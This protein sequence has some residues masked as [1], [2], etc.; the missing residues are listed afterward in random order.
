MKLQGSD[1]SLAIKNFG[2]KARELKSRL[3]QRFSFRKCREV[4][5]S[6]KYIKNSEEII[7]SIKEPGCERMESRVVSSAQDSKFRFDLISDEKLLPSTGKTC[8]YDG[9]ND[10]SSITNT[11]CG[12]DPL[13]AGDVEI[14]ISEMPDY[15]SLDK[16]QS[17]EFYD[18][19]EELFESPSTK[20]NDMHKSMRNEENNKDDSL[21]KTSSQTM[22]IRE[23]C[24]EEV[25]VEEKVQRQLT[26][27]F[28]LRTGL[29]RNATVLKDIEMPENGMLNSEFVLR[30][31]TDRESFVR[32]C[33]PYN[34]IRD[35]FMDLER[36]P[37]SMTL[38]LGEESYRTLRGEELR[39][40]VWPTFSKSFWIFL[41]ACDAQ[42][43]KTKSMPEFQGCDQYFPLELTRVLAKFH[44]SFGI[45]EKGLFKHSNKKAL[46][47]D[48]R[49][50]VLLI[51]KMLGPLQ[52]QFSELYYHFDQLPDGPVKAVLKPMFS[53]SQIDED[54]K[55]KSKKVA[56]IHKGILKLLEITA[57]SFDIENDG[58]WI[59]DEVDN[60]NSLD[61]S[62]ERAFEQLRSGMQQKDPLIF[63]KHLV[64]QIVNN[65]RDEEGFSGPSG[66]TIF[67]EDIVVTPDALREKLR[68][69]YEKVIVDLY[70][71]IDPLLGTISVDGLSIIE[72]TTFDCIWREIELDLPQP[73]SQKE[74]SHFFRLKSK[75]QQL[76]EGR[77]KMLEMAQT[78][79]SDLAKTMD[80]QIACM[81]TEKQNK[82]RT[83]GGG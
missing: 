7:S 55:C 81:Q 35:A 23:A 18:G 67:P 44:M 3:K 74:S 21:S 22:S 52:Q 83:L 51:L 27:I 65:I 78:E 61:L 40:A 56:E 76:Q 48:E 64:S 75:K 6:K 1:L 36:I 34:L 60:Q 57:S 14:S 4:D 77:Q 53:D 69:F 19:L 15:P 54:G 38:I 37:E 46:N 62:V 73:T 39:D 30:A 32:L 25:R 43:K 63:Y 8:F 17:V 72:K 10:H 42:E 11:S 26:Q 41:D 49:R 33:N 58:L 59:D 70:D 71:Q 2:Y 50:E 24:S 82:L 45:A 5:S 31:I 12:N 29:S 9:D 16:L 68:S 80:A 79:F 47:S 28:I 13:S 66:K 20:N